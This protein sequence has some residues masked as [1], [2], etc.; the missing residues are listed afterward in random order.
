MKILTNTTAD[1]VKL[2]AI[3][4]PDKGLN[5]T[6]FTK[7]GIEA[8]DPKTHP[9]FDERC[10]GLGALIGPHFHHRRKEDIPPLKDPNL[11]PH[12]AKILASGSSEPFSHGIAR[13]VPWNVKQENNVL[14]GNL[15]GHDTYKGH[16]LKE[17]EGQ[18][19]A[20]F[21]KASLEPDGLYIE[22]SVESERPSV[23]GFHYYYNLYG[24]EA[25]F[26]E[27]SVAKDYRANQGW[28]PLPSTW[29]KEGKLHFSLDQESDF[30]FLPE[31]KSRSGHIVLKTKKYEQH[32]SYEAGQDDHSWQ[33]YHPEKASFACIEP[34]SAKEPRNPVLT[35][36]SLKVKL[37]IR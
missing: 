7:G 19:F 26:V 30:G 5:L 21:F 3:F 34:L 13:Y 12:T 17:L 27:A 10:A 29:E 37:E 36:S 31:D 25:A 4:D 23:V 24:D 2:E 35:S 16:P 28:S 15:S 11:F 32:V 8:I 20:M 14:K 9:L 6:S 22:L 1:G 33:L 18:D